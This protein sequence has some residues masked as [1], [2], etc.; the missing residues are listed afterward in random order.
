ME[1]E[2][3]AYYK[4]SGL[5]PQRLWELAHYITI[6]SDGSVTE[7]KYYSTISNDFHYFNPP[8][9]WD[10]DILDSYILT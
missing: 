1:G 4:G 8:R 9:I 2:Y 7:D 3:I 6:H 10:R 5:Y